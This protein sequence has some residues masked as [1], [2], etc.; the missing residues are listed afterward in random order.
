MAVTYNAALKNTRITAVLTAIDSGGAGTLEIGTAGFGTTLASLALA[1][2][3]GT[4]TGAVL[5]FDTSPA[6]TA[7][8]SGTGTAAAARIKDNGGTVVVSGLTVGTVGTDIILSQSPITSGDTVNI[9][10]AT[11]TEP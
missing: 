3:S 7:T 4:V 9:T 8:A 11:I 1:N 10:A 6:L 2:P 5:T